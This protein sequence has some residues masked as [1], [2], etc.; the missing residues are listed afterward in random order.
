MQMLAIIG[1]CFG[2]RGASGVFSIFL[3]T[4]SH[5]SLCDRRDKDVLWDVL[6]SQ[7]FTRRLC[8]VLASSDGT[9]SFNLSINW[10]LDNQN[11]QNENS[12]VDLDLDLIRAADKR[13]GVVWS[14][15]YIGIISNRSCDVSMTFAS[16][17]ECW[18]DKLMMTIAFLVQ[19]SVQYVM[20]D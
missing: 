5:C 8:A 6:A 1:L 17:W 14:E 12:A 9:S 18:R 3:S 2:G 19:Y 16:L 4:T 13:V 11:Q 20:T 15:E 10:F 7:V